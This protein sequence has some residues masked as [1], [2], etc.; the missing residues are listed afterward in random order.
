MRLNISHETAYHYDDE[1]RASIQ[2]L[3]L[4]PHDSERQRI[5]SWQLDLPRPVRAQLAQNVLQCRSIGCAHDDLGVARLLAG[6]ANS[7]VRDLVVT[8]MQKDEVQDLRERLRVDDMAVEV[9]G[10]GGHK[11]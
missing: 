8:A 2:Y 3:R 4:T 11:G 6:R 9:N 5:L 10:F 7:E 1:V